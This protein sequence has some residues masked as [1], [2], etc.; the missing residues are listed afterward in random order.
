MPTIEIDGTNLYYSVKGEGTPIV[1]I[2]PP[3]LTSANFIY[4]VEEL[5]QTFKVITFDIKGH[6]RS[7]YSKQ[8]ITY[9]LI[10][11]D[12]IYLLD[13]L[14]IEKAFICGY[15]TG[16]SIVL[17][18]L[19]SN[20]SRALGGIVISGMS[21]VNDL[22]LKQRI[23]LAGK[24]AKSKFIPVLSFAIT[25]GNSNTRQIFKKMYKE[26]SFGDARNIEQYYR[27]S[28]SFNCTKQLNKINL[29]VLLVYGT[30]D[31]S[32]HK[33]AHL[34]HKELP[35]NDLVLLDKEKHQIPTKA[36]SKLNE[37]IIAFVETQK[38]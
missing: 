8:T 29:P 6:G 32:F 22:F 15:S 5:S 33:Y 27:Y 10:V 38:Y 16:G 13:Y 12:L 28:L 31:Q 2:H 26:S 37:K 25:W 4:Q 9:P 14:E 19:L 7:G 3:L 11:K 1:F 17:E 21:E 20:A 24:L 30:K 18:F 36:A 34:L 35:F 23:S